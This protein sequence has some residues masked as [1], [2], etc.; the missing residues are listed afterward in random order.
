MI[1]GG[2][3]DAHADLKNIFCCVNDQ[4]VRFLVLHSALLEKKLYVALKLSLTA[5]EIVL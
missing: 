3:S 5:R 1:R 4:V 2:L